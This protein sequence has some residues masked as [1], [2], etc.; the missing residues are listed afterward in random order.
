MTASR[1]RRGARRAPAEPS[2]RRW[3]ILVL[4]PLLVA[5]GV[6]VQHRQDVQA[7]SVAVVSPDGFQPTASSS[8]ATSSTWYCAAGTAT[9]TATG[10]AEQTVQIANDSDQ[11][12]SGRLTAFPSA[13]DS[14][15]K[16]LDLPAHGRVDVVVSTLVK[17]PYAS[18]LVEV[19]GGEVAVSHLLVGPTGRSVAACSSSPSE[20]WYVPSGTTRPGTTQQLALF[21]PFPSEAVVNVTFQAD[22]G[23]RSPQAYSALVVP[24]QSLKVLDISA[25][26]TLRDH[27]STVVTV[28]SGRVVIDQVQSADGTQGTTKSLTVTPAAP[29]SSSTWWFPDGPADAGSD[30]VYHVQNPTD[31][32][33]EV[34]LRIRLD[35]TVSYGAVEPFR[36]EVQPGEYAA[37]DVT[38][39][40]RV[41]AGVGYAAV[42]QSTNG[43]AI[44]ADRVV[45][46]APPATNV[47]A[48][49]MMGSP[50]TASRWIVP[51]ASLTEA[52]AVKVIVTNTSSSD[53]VTLTVST[54]ADGRST[55]L[56]GMQNVVVDAGARGGTT[57]TVGIPVAV[58]TAPLSTG[59]TGTGN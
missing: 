35:D 40:G 55:P 15:K 39:D 56:P 51:S 54:L 2:P 43:V 59:P 41:P 46:Y 23:T 10:A 34:E 7:P 32:V 19:D 9:G 26:V 50:T 21:N 13:G 8:E 58:A 57:A 18:A 44:V 49:V 48:T 17:A 11:A 52:S 37:I 47:G 5:V 27:L 53:P 30:A 20:S 6:V 33:A 25:T 45:S 12:L 1:S 3:P 24:G 28:R 42:A 38:T 16:N 31:Q 14:V 4:L 22:D 29:R 36:V